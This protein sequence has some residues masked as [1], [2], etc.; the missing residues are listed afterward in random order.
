MEKDFLHSNGGPMS[1][2]SY[3]SKI[4]LCTLIAFCG[5]PLNASN[6]I[7]CAIHEYE[8]AAQSGDLK[9]YN[10]TCAAL[11]EVAKTADSS[12]AQLCRETALKAKPQ[13]NISRFIAALICGANPVTGIRTFSFLN[14]VVHDL[15][16]NNSLCTV[17]SVL[18]SLEAGF[19]TIV[20]G[21]DAITA[22]T[23]SKNKTM[24]AVFGLCILSLPALLWTAIYLNHTS[25]KEKNALDDAYTSLIKSLDETMCK[26]NSSTELVNTAPINV[27][28]AA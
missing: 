1:R 7:G 26:H 23:N 22:I 8:K 24:G 13:S 15:V 10:Q 27:V 19:Y 12:E 17:T 18:A 4:L 11:I 28:Q 25:S 16:P 5:A 14:T 20:V 3:F 9:R 6:N 21:G 2:L